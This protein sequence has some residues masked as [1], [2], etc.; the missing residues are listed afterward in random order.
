VIYMDKVLNKEHIDKLLAMINNAPF[1]K[2]LG[3]EI[4]ELKKGY[5]R[6]EVLLGE[7]HINSFGSIHGGVCASLIDTAAYWAGYCGREENE[8][9]TSLDLSVTNLSMAKKGRLIAEGH[10][11]KEGRSICLSEVTVT[12]ENGKPIAHGI[13]K[14]MI[15]SGKQSLSDAIENLGY[16]PLPPKFEE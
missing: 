9:F 11:I 7:N 3:I 5:S 15:L 1:F 6:V 14:L 8:G 16:P 2:H 13:S 10:T 4:K 12:D